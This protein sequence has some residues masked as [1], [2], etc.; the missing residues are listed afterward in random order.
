MDR[1][2]GIAVIRQ[3]AWVLAASLAL[4]AC[5]SGQAAQTTVD[6]SSS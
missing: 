4:A 5:G 3:L 2:A 6:H 1:E